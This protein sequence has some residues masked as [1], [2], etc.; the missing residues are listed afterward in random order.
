MDAVLE[1]FIRRETRRVYPA[2]SD[3]PVNALV[4][5]VDKRLCRDKV[6]GRSDPFGLRQTVR[7]YSLEQAYLGKG[8]LHARQKGQEATASPPPRPNTTIWICWSASTKR[9]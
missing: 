7:I 9:N 2:C 6:A 8:V 3:V 4:Y 5:R 1:S